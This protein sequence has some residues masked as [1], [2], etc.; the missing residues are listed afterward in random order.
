MPSLLE[1]AAGTRAAR[2]VVVEGRVQGVGF[3]PFVYRLAEQLGLAGTVQ[4][5]TG[6]V[7]ILAEGDSEALDAFERG[8][9]ADAPPLARPAIKQ[10]RDATPI[11]ADAFRILPSAEGEAAAIHLPPDLF[12]CD[13]C[14]AEMA[15][16]A[17][18]RYRYPFTNCTQCGPRYTIIAALPYDRAATSMAG[19]E[20][21]PEC[22]GEYAD[23]GD[24]RF[25]AQPLA[26]P[27]CGPR[28]SF[29]C[30]QET[31]TGEAALDAALAALRAGQLVAVKG[32]GGYHLMCDAASDAALV[33]LRARKHRPDKPLAVMVPQ[34]GADGLDAAREI[35]VPG[36]IEAAALAAP[37]RP[38][39]LVRRR[40]NAPLSELVAPGLDEVG[41]FLPYSPLHHLLLD[42]FG[43]P[44][45]ATSG[46]ISG[47]PVLTD[48]GEAAARLGEIA[49][50]FLDHDR[51]ILRPADDSVLRIIAGVA[52]PLR[53]GR[54]FAPL[55]LDTERE[56]AEPVLALGG[57]MKG[58]IALG[59][60]KRI[61]VSPHIGELD[62]PR[63]LEMFE[64][65]AA[66]L[67]R[68]YRVEAT[69]LACDAHPQYASSRWAARQG[70]PVVEVQHH[71]AHASGLAGEHEPGLTWLIF[72]W[73]G[74]GLGENS[75]IWGGETLL[76][77]PGA[78]RRIASLGK[79]ELPGGDKAAREPW[80]SAASLVWETGRDWVPAVGDG[81]L[82]RAAWDKRL[83]TTSCSSAGRLFD[84]AAAMVLGVEK[85]SYEG[86]GPMQLEALARSWDGPGGDAPALP[87]A[88]DTQGLLRA[89]W[90]PLLAMLNDDTLAAAQRAA[91][92][93]ESLAQTILAQTRLL[94]EAH[95]FDAVGLTGGVF[96]NRLLAERALAL[97]EA[98]GLRAHLPAKVPAN[99]GGL[100]FG[101]LIEAHEVL[102]G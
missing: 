52:R 40:A 74:T 25:H 56:F 65:V 24:R 51:P 64:Q 34:R 20:L 1:R 45:V 39:V 7:H 70:L 21:C 26:C 91:R 75:E 71:H 101:Q 46:N 99:D 31:A 76:G 6:E 88:A 10:A 43:G 87:L 89:D 77:R 83:G 79:F 55:E 67:Q 44:L 17:G 93:H 90:S 59:F 84:A 53:I 58:S 73:D 49:D 30:G 37:E 14:L 8:L 23:P 54:G 62:S 19:F 69:R 85:V 22:A 78:W 18:R 60:G 95:A 63:A 42:G 50:A 47:E 92:F 11:G 68:L 3:R 33:R 35:A 29:R 12:C 48:P 81:A 27:A 86:Q 15:D 72:A 57:H 5:R 4:N 102:Q 94:A 82:A 96:Q 100:A 97:L 41:L 9:V 2:L 36:P 61:V 38:I 98:E 66:D 13:D 80:R 16:P 32:I 28:L